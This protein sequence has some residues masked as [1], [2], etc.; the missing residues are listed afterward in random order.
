MC[1]FSLLSSLNHK[2]NRGEVPSRAWSLIV[3]SEL[4]RCSA[5][6]DDL[7][8]L[9][10]DCA[11]CLLDWYIGNVDGERF[12]ESWLSLYCS[13]YERE[14]RTSAAILDWY[15]RRLSSLKHFERKVLID[16]AENYLVETGEFRNDWRSIY[17]F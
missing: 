14:L 15:C 11:C 17:E 3:R 2:L 12:P 16:I 6:V 4:N 1:T 7:P 5:I 9:E 8:V 10:R 13:E